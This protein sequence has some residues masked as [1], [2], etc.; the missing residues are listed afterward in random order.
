MCRLGNLG[1]ISTSLPEKRTRTPNGKCCAEL[2]AL[3]SARWCLETLGGL[4]NSMHSLRKQNTTKQNTVKDE[5][6]EYKNEGEKLRHKSLRKTQQTR[7]TGGVMYAIISYTRSYWSSKKSY[8]QSF[9]SSKYHPSLSQLPLNYVSESTLHSC[10][11]SR[12]SRCPS[13]SHSAS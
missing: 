8:Y 10:S 9:S 13:I 3:Y 11:A 4:G 5:N 2:L 7:N 6:A 12:P 1:S